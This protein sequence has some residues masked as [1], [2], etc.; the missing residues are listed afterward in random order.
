M[1]ALFTSHTHTTYH[2]H[3]L[4]ITHTLTYVSAYFLSHIHPHQPYVSFKYSSTSAPVTYHTLT[5]YHSN[6]LP[7]SVPL[8]THTLTIYNSHT[9]S[10]HTHL[11]LTHHLPLIHTP[12]SVPITTHTFTIYHSPM[13]ASLTYHTSISVP[14]ISHTLTTYRS[15]TVY[16][17]YT[18]PC[19]SQLPLTQSPI[20]EPFTSHTLTIYRS[21][22]HPCPPYLLSYTH[23]LSLTH[24]PM[25]APHTIHTITHVSPTYHSHTH[26]C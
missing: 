4:F 9:H 22:T 24:S 25:L 8:T 6:T 20:L 26:L 17:L 3:S 13:S 10:C 11:P 21:H 2:P 18:H 23:H 14:L 15:H 5:T 16:H 12:M 1:S 19:Q 7:M